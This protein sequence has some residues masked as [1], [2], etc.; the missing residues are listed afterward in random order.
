MAEFDLLEKVGKIE[1]RYNEIEHQLSDPAL[2]SDKNLLPKLAKERSR[3]EPAVLAIKSYKSLVK[4]IEEDKQIIGSEKDQDL[5]KIAKDELKELEEKLIPLEKQL[6]K[7]LIPPDPRDHKNI[8]MEIRA[9]TGGEEAALFAGDLFRMYSKFAE[10]EGWSQEILSSSPSEKGGFKEVIF[11][12]SGER[13]YSK[14]KYE[15][16]VHRVQRVPVTEANGRIHTSAASV[17]VLAEPDEIEEIQID[18]TELRIDVYRS[19]GPGGQHVNTTDSAVRITHLPSG[20]V[21]ACQ[22]ERSQHKNKAKCMK[23]LQARLISIRIEKQQNKEAATRKSQIAGGDRSAKIRTYNFPQ[24]RMTDHRIGLTLYRL[25]SIMN[26]DIE[27]IAE[28]LSLVEQT[29]KLS[30]LDL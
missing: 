3:L 20:I 4:Q 10:K 19:S 25:D 11:S 29:E 21:V 27:E 26:G 9:G 28:Q 8:I 5:V 7:H 14:M 17:V 30:S 16:G 22:E 12:I 1:N 24:G 13:V 15:S 6:K 18:P 2:L 23:I